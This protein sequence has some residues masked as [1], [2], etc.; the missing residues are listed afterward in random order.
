M[1]MVVAG[2]AL[3]VALVTATA[4][5]AAEGEF[6]VSR[7]IDKETAAAILEGQ[8]KNPAPRNIAGKDGYYSKCNYYSVAGGKT[9]IIRFYQAGAGYDPNK[10][11]DQVQESSGSMRSISSFGDKA[12]LSIGAESGLPAHVVMLYVV[13]GNSLITVGVGGFDDDV[14]VGKAKAVAQKILAQLSE[15]H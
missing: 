10:E 1:R 5:R 9:L 6:D 2:V 4:L 11:L 8:I 14:A 3:T 7:V 12:R 15:G 13:K